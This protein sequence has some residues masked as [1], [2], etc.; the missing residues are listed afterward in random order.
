MAPAKKFL[1]VGYLPPTTYSRETGA[2]V[3]M[4]HLIGSA[5]VHRG[6]FAAMMHRKGLVK[7]GHPDSLISGIDH[8]LAFGPAY[9]TGLQSNS[10]RITILHDHESL[11]SNASYRGVRLR[12][13]S[14]QMDG[15]TGN[16]ARW[17]LFRDE[18][19]AEAAR[20]TQCAFVVD[21]GDVYPTTPHLRQLCEAHP[22]A[23][24]VASDTCRRRQAW[25]WLDQARRWSNF[26]ASAS[27][28]VVLKRASS[29]RLMFN[30]GILGGRAALLRRV[31]GRVAD[32]IAAHS[33]ELSARG[34]DPHASAHGALPVDMLSLHEVLLELDPGSSLDDAQDGADYS[35][36]AQKP[37]SARPT[38][39]LSADTQRALDRLP[40]SARAEVLA[41]LAS[42]ASAAASKEASRGSGS[43]SRTRGGRASGSRGSPS[44]GSTARR[45]I[46]IVTG[47]P[48]GPINMPMHG[49]MCSDSSCFQNHSAAKGDKDCIKRELAMSSADH[50]WRH[51]L[52]CG[53]MIPCAAYAE[54][55][56]R[57]PPIS[58]DGGGVVSEKECSRL[59]S[60]RVFRNERRERG[61]PDGTVVA[62]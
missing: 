9:D 6:G 46:D 5:N 34:I 1:N 55:K 32:R 35:A 41:A 42:A 30:S 2:V 54:V 49:D 31:V 37:P 24:F 17:P 4:A 40:E 36:A 11:A 14:P 56:V 22:G 48:Y 13:S 33:R 18:L 45:S 43:G 15:V 39:G 60:C 59:T 50:F 62:P 23:L 8:M 25:A 53:R 51:K 61:L 21:L 28:D 26:T 44:E 12:H 29:S 27:L 38:G 16:D 20:G 10:L 3:I 47:W 19:H 58:I 57:E 7:L 52:A